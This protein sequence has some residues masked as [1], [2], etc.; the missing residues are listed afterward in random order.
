MDIISELK[1]ILVKRENN[2]HESRDPRTEKMV[3]TDLVKW[4][5]S[6]SDWN[7]FHGRRPGLLENCTKP[8][9]PRDIDHFKERLVARSTRIG[10]CVD[11]WI[12]ASQASLS[13]VNIK[14]ILSDQSLPPKMAFWVSFNQNF[15]TP[16]RTVDQ[17]KST[18]R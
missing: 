13:T 10:R 3:R 14:I 9:S 6:S 17:V 12:R 15:S 5:L 16:T 7:P 1:W 2:K 8:W 4:Y 18:D 11:P